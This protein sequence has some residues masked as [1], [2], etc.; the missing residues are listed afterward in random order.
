MFTY[1]VIINMEYLV[2]GNFLYMYIY[3]CEYF[4][5]NVNIIAAK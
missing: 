3:N 5:F 1:T 2:P 4:K